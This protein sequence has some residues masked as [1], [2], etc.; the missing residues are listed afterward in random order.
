MEGCLEPIL[1]DTLLD[2]K[3]LC[4]SCKK[5]YFLINYSLNDEE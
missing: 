3:F 1:N 4:K 2:S 5:G